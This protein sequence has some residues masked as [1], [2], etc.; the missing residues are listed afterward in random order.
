MRQSGDRKRKERDIERGDRE[1]REMRIRGRIIENERK[2]DIE[3]KVREREKERRMSW[4]EREN[5]G[6]EGIAGERK[7][8]SEG[9]PS[10]FKLN[11]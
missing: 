7:K 11:H 6:K 9:P 10:R 3:R 1:R 2:K 8:N 4:R 5:R